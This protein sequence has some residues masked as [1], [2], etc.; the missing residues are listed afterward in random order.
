MTTTIDK[1]L[2]EQVP[3]PFSGK[4]CLCQQCID[5]FNAEKVT[6]ST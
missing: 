2:L 6:D 4:A 5:K 1:R 3:E